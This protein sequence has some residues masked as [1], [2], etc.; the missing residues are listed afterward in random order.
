[1]LLFNEIGIQKGN[2][3]FELIEVVK[4]KKVELKNG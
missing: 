1:M 4:L 3:E 2:Q